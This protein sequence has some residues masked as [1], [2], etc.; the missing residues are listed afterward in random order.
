[1]FWETKGATF[2]SAQIS[3]FEFVVMD[4]PRLA[5]S[6]P[7]PNAF[8]EYLQTCSASACAF[9]NL[10]GDAI[11]VAP[12]QQ[13]DTAAYSHLGKFV[14]E[15]PVDQVRELWQVTAQTYLERLKVEKPVW[16]STEGSGVPWLHVRLDDRPKYYKYAPYYS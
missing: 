13:A 6:S 9:S 5:E 15:A 3:D 16:L 4:A 2:Q 8:S 12:V 14:R 11:L 1:M 10:G 7:D